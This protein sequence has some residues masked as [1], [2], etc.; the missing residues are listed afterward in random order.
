[1][2][3]WSLWSKDELKKVVKTFNFEEDLEKY[4][5]KYHIDMRSHK[6]LIEP[7]E[8]TNTYILMRKK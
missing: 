2:L 4:I 8:Y 5:K 3:S 1:M 7:D 6:V